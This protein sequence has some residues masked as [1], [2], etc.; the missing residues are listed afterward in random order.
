MGV[1]QAD[2]QRTWALW[3]LEQLDD[4]DPV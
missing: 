2:A 1:L 4:A 3:A